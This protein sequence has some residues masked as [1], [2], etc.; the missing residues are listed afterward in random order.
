MMLKLLRSTSDTGESGQ[1]R[2]FLMVEMAK[3]KRRVCCNEVSHG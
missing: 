3:V 1:G 2:V